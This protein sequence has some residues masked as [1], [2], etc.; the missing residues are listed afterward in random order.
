LVRVTPKYFKK[1]RNVRL[2]DVFELGTISAMHWIETE[3]WGGARMGCR[4]RLF[5]D[6]TIK[7]I[8]EE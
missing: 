7:Q 3:M 8:K 4:P 6:S 1:T 2:I 5:V